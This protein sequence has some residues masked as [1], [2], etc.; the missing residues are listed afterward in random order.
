MQISSG[1]NPDPII[2]RWLGAAW[3]Q[4]WPHSDFANSEAQ[5]GATIVQQQLAPN[6]WTRQTTAAAFIE[7]NIGRP[8]LHVLVNAHVTRILFSSSSPSNLTATG[9]E[10][11]W[12]NNNRTYQVSASREVI[13]SAGSI[14]SPQLLM[15]SGIGPRD[16]LQSFG[17]PVLAE[18]PV[19]DHL[20]DH[21]MILMDFSA[22][23]VSDIGWSGS[24]YYNLNVENLYSYYTRATGPLTRILLPEVYFATGVNGNRDWPDTASYM[25]ILQYCECTSGYLKFILYLKF[26]SLFFQR[27]PCPSSRR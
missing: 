22:V 10:F 14:N 20:A 4:G 26:F 7:P 23:N 24:M 9:V 27:P 19:G 12:A 21:P 15:L 13:L 8:N 17:I 11:V 1:P 5:F 16:H 2:N 18:L 25:L 3:A 6:N